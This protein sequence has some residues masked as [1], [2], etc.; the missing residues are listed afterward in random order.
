[1][2]TFSCFQNLICVHPRASAVPFL[3]VFI[4]FFLTAGEAHVDR[5]LEHVLADV[6]LVGLLAD[7]FLHL[8]CAA[9]VLERG[10]SQRR[11]EPRRAVYR[12]AAGHA[13]CV[14]T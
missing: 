2:V 5:A 1:M 13:L 7:Q 4:A 6:Q 14:A 3:R 9:D 8:G 10:H 11:R 12:Y